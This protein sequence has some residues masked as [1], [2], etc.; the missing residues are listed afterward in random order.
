MDVSAAGEEELTEVRVEAV[1]CTTVEI[2]SALLVD[3]PVIYVGTVD[4]PVEDLVVC[5]T[6][7]WCCL[8]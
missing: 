5:N 7:L 4:E 1:D 8:W 2:N 3:V 6:S